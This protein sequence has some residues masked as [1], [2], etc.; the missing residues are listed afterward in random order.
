VCKH[1]QYKN[2]AEYK[3]SSHRSHHEL[4]I[5]AH[6]CPFGCERCEVVT[7]KPLSKSQQV[8]RNKKKKSDKIYKC[9]HLQCCKDFSESHNRDRH[10]RT[11]LHDNALCT[12]DPTL[13]SI[14]ASIPRPPK[15]RKCTSCPNPE[16]PMSDGSAYSTHTA[17]NAPNGSSPKGS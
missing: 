17:Q 14:P 13:D 2:R 3:Q 11:V 7:Q 9:R 15:K 8:F 1:G 10:E 6:T 5:D 4:N 12:P 16:E